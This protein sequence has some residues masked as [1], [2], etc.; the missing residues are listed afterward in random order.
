MFANHCK[1]F[2]AKLICNYENNAFLATM[3]LGQQ[4]VQKNL[5]TKIDIT[6]KWLTHYFPQIKFK[7]LATQRKRLG[8]KYIHLLCKQCIL[9]QMRNC[10]IKCFG[11]QITPNKSHSTR[12]ILIPI[13]RY[14]TFTSYTN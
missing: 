8:S 4:L 13:S 12:T 1:N 6:I 7:L 9:P 10:D 14:E 3:R 5:R 11:V 2:G